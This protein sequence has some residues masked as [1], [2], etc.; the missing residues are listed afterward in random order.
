VVY[1]KILSEVQNH[2]MHTVS[3]TI[4]FRNQRRVKEQ[5]N[6]LMKIGL[7]FGILFCL[8][9]VI[10]SLVG[11]WF[12]SNLTR[13]LPSIDT[14]PS[15]LEPPEGSLL[16]PTRLFDRTH[17]H[18]IATL[19]NP[20]VTGERYL[21]IGTESQ[22]EGEQFSKYLIDAT[23]VASDSGFWDHPGFTL[24]GWSEGT[25]PTLAQQLI[26]DLVLIDEPASL[27]RNIRERLLAAQITNVFGREKILEW[28][29]N[30]AP[31][32]DLIYGADAA[33]LA[34][35]GKS[36]TMLDLA[37]AA[38]L[39]AIS[40]SPAI[41]PYSGSQ[42]LKLQQGQVL[43]AMLNQGLITADEAQNALKKDLQFKIEPASHPI[44]PAFTE[45]VLEQLSSRINLDRIK[46]GGFDIVTTLD[47]ELQMQ[48]KCATE[49]Q[50]DRI[51]GAEENAT[52]K[53]VE[54]CEAAK[55]LPNLQLSNEDQLEDISANVVVLDP[56][57]GQILAL[58]GDDTS[59]RY[60]MQSTEH[61]AGTILSPLLY[62][63]AF[64]RGINPA[65][66]LWDIPNT[67]GREN[68]E[69]DQNN[70]MQGISTIFHGPVRARIALVNDY[71]AATAE[72]LKQVRIE[73]LLLTEKRFG[74]ENSEVQPSPNIT[75]EDLFSRKISLL[76]ASSAYGVLANQGLM[77]SQPNFEEETEND[78]D[79]LNPTSVLQVIGVEGK[80]WLDWSNAQT[81]PIV[82]PQLAF[83]A[84]HVLSDENARRPSLGHP[85]SLE[86][87]RPAAAKIGITDKG[88]DAWTIGYIPQLVVGTWLGHTREKTGGISWELPA[89][90]WHAIT[91]YAS[92]HMPVKEFNV[93]KGISLV[94]VCDPS[95]LLISE[96]CP[97]IAQEA[98]L[99]GNEP[100]Q[101]D[102]LYQ[103]YSVNRETGSLATIF[104]PP[105]MVEEKVFLEVPSQAVEWASNSG[106]PLPPDT[107]DVIYATEP[108]LPDVQITSPQTFDHVSA[109][110]HFF[111]SAAGP[112]FS[113]YRLQVGK[114]L[115]PQEWVQIGDDINKP[116]KD[117]LLGTWDTSGLEGL[118]VVQ[119]QV[120]RQDRSVDKDNLQLTIDNT[121]PQVEILTPT[122]GEEISFQLGESILMQVSASD[123]L[124]LER[125]EFVVDGE[126]RMTLLQPPLIIL[127]PERMGEHKLTVRAYDLAG[128]SG[129]SSISF[130]VNK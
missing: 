83:L 119:L 19:E 110:V 12:Y 107:Y 66:L 51:L 22:A 30:S 95:G 47:Y 2:P 97:T 126:L 50:I 128:N 37:E 121:Q 20:A 65:T 44:A 5:A 46:R 108:K 85:N 32:G 61:T 63:S 90:L 24:A 59:E 120:V 57:T 98:F 102:N 101:V 8:V 6:P 116:V 99:Q 72:V 71:L 106:F 28:Y 94:Q 112:N 125:V 4:K 41:S 84:T 74:I 29:L 76:E 9:G 15:L 80:I 48:A 3:Q 16:H 56:L 21:S 69:S 55:L 35:F 91:K 81:K 103:K 130:S 77:V 42:V 43:Q 58:V 34:Y 75:I 117:G 64:A 70:L 38:M 13:D 7:G 17:E 67:T 39:A 87:G 100:T 92:R 53:E 118:Y 78:M 104:T 49:I 10:G 86:I 79:G 45:K 68:V 62:I 23:I 54:V 27:Q 89:G 122:E 109:Q 25:H 73:N 88:D 18:V 113:F 1:K 111:G 105:D 127:W 124:M 52:N 115:N 26:A 82:S 33:A 96:L 60:P 14:L 123:N 129:E 40:K 11:V 31:Y 36:A 114:G 93:P